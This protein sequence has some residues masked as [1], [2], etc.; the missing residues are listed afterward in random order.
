MEELTKEMYPD[1]IIPSPHGAIGTRTRSQSQGRVTEEGVKKS[2]KSMRGR[3][4]T[5]DQPSE[6]PMPKSSSAPAGT[7]ATTIGIDATGQYSSQETEILAPQTIEDPPVIPSHPEQSQIRPEGNPPSTPD[8]RDPLFTPIPTGPGVNSELRDALWTTPLGP[9]DQQSRIIPS[10]NPILQVTP[11][12]SR[13]DQRQ[14][15]AS[16]W[17]QE[18]QAQLTQKQDIQAT[19]TAESSVS[20]AVSE[21]T[22]LRNSIMGKSHQ[23]QPIAMTYDHLPGYSQNLQDGSV[24]S[25]ASSHGSFTAMRRGLHIFKRDPIWEMLPISYQLK[26]LFNNFLA[27]IRSYSALR[28]I[29]NNEVYSQYKKAQ[30]RIQ[31]ASNDLPQIIDDIITTV[32]ESDIKE[33]F[34]L[35]INNDLD[36]IMSKAGEIRDSLEEETEE[37]EAKLR[38]Q[39]LSV[40]NLI[41]RDFHASTW[42]LNELEP[43]HKENEGADAND[44]IMRDQG[45]A[46]MSKQEH[47]PG[48]EG[49]NLR[50]LHTAGKDQAI[51]HGRSIRFYDDIQEYQYP[52]QP[53]TATPT[54]STLKVKMPPRLLQ[55][56][57]YKNKNQGHP[58]YCCCPS[59]M[60]QIIPPKYHTAYLA[61]RTS[62]NDNPAGQSSKMPGRDDMDTGIIP[63]DQAYRVQEVITPPE[64]NPSISTREHTDTRLSHVTTCAEGRLPPSK[65]GTLLESHKQWQAHSGNQRS[66]APY[67]DGMKVTT[68]DSPC[69][70]AQH[71]EEAQPPRAISDPIREIGS[72]FPRRDV[73]QV[74]KGQEHYDLAPSQP[75]GDNREGVQIGPPH[76]QHQPHHGTHKGMGPSKQ[77]YES[78]WSKGGERSHNPFRRPCQDTHGKSSYPPNEYAH[79]NFNARSSYSHHTPSHPNN[80]FPLRGQRDKN[81]GSRN[82]DHDGNEPRVQQDRPPPDSGSADHHHSGQ[83]LMDHLK[84]KARELERSNR[85]MRA[86]LEEI[87]DPLTKNSHQLTDHLRRRDSTIKFAN[88]HS[89]KAFNFEEQFHKVKQYLSQ[90]A[91]TYYEE[92][93]G[94]AHGLDRQV[95]EAT[96]ETAKKARQ[97]GLTISRPGAGTGNQLHYPNF[98]ESS[99]EMH[100]YEWLAK[101]KEN[102]EIMNTDHNMRAS[103]LK[104][105]LQGNAK[106]VVNE[107]MKTEEEV[108]QTLTDKYGDM[109]VIFK[110][111]NLLHDEV[112]A[113][114]GYNDRN[115]TIMREIVSKVSRHMNLIKRKELMLKYDNI[116]KSYERTLHSVEHFKKLKSLL[117]LAEGAEIHGIEK[118]DPLNAYKRIRG[119][120]EKL[121][122]NSG[123][124]YE[125]LQASTELAARKSPQEVPRVKGKKADYPEIVLYTSA[126]NTGCKICQLQKVEGIGKNHHENHLF[127][128]ANNSHPSSCPNYL[129]MGMSRRKE[130]LQKH[131]ICHYCLK[132]TEIGHKTPFD[133]CRE[134]MLRRKTTIGYKCEIHAC[135]HRTENC[136]VHRAKNLARL[137]KRAKSLKEES[138]IDFIFIGVDEEKPEESDTSSGDYFKSTSPTSPTSS[139]T[140]TLQS[141]AET[142]TVAQIPSPAIHPP[143]QHQNLSLH[144][145]FKLK[146]Y[147]PLKIYMYKETKSDREVYALGEILEVIKQTVKQ[148]N[149]LDSQNESIIF[150]SQALIAVLG[151]SALH[152]SQVRG[153]ILPQLEKLPD[154]DEMAEP[155][156]GSPQY[157]RKI[158]SRDQLFFL[159]PDLLKIIHTMASH[160]EEIKHQLKFTFQKVRELIVKFILSNKESFFDTRNIKVAIVKNSPLGKA[161]GVQAFHHSQL[162]DL[163]MKNLVPASPLLPVITAINQVTK[164]SAIKRHSLEPEQALNQ[165]PPKVNKQT[166]PD[167][168]ERTQQLPELPL[169]MTITKAQQPIEGLETSPLFCPNGFQ[170]LPRESR[171]A[172]EI[173]SE[174]K[175]IML[176]MY[177]KGKTRPL[178]TIFDTG[179]T[180]AVMR[181]DVPGKELIG[182]KLVNSEASLHGFGVASEPMKKYAI[183]IPKMNGG[184]LMVEGHAVDN[185]A[186]V[187]SQET[188]EAVHHL[189]KLAPEN[190]EVQQAKVH[191]HVGG[192]IDLVIGIRYLKHFPQLIFKSNQEYGLYE[193]RLLP[194]Y[195]QYKHCLGG[196]NP[197]WHASPNQESHSTRFCIPPPPLGT[198]VPKNTNCWVT[199]AVHCNVIN[200]APGGRITPE[201]P[202]NDTH[203][204]Q[205]KL[206]VAPPREPLT[207]NATHQDHPIF[208]GTYEARTSNVQEKSN[209]VSHVLRLGSNLPSKGFF[210]ALLK[211]KSRPLLTFFSPHHIGVIIRSDI[212]GNEVELLADDGKTV[213]IL[214]PQA[215]GSKTSTRAHKALQTLDLKVTSPRLG[216]SAFNN[217]KYLR[218]SQPHK[219]YLHIDGPA[220]LIIGKSHKRLHPQP[221]H[222]EETGCLLYQT[223]LQLHTEDYK[224][225]AE[226]I[227]YRANADSTNQPTT[228]S[229]EYCLLTIDSSMGKTYVFEQVVEQAAKPSGIHEATDQDLQALLTRSR[230]KDMLKGTKSHK[231]N[232]N[233]VRLQEDRPLLKGT[234]NDLFSHCTSGPYLP[235]EDE[236]PEKSILWYQ[237]MEG[238]TRPIVTVFD[239]GCSTTVMRDD[240]PGIQL[241]ATKLPDNATTLRGIGGTQGTT[242]RYAILL[243]QADQGYKMAEGYTVKE[244]VKLQDYNIQRAL[245]QI[246]K[247]APT[248]EE[249]QHAQIHPNIGGEIDMLIGIHRL[250]TFP[251][252]VHETNNGLGLYRLKLRSQNINHKYCLGGKYVQSRRRRRNPISLAYIIENIQNSLLTMTGQEALHF[253]QN[254]AKGTAE[255]DLAVLC[256]SADMAENDHI[257]HDRE[258]VIMGIAKPPTNGKLAN[259]PQLKD[260]STRAAFIRELH[261]LLDG[262]LETNY[263]CENCIS[264]LTCKQGESKQM[265]SISQSIEEKL[266]RSTIKFDTETRRFTARLPIQGDASTLL[267]PNRDMAEKS[268]RGQL[269]RISNIPEDINEIKI[270]FDKLV[271]KGFIARLNDL[272]EHIRHEILSQELKHYIPWVLAYK[273]GSLSTPVRIC[274]DA[275]R[276]TPSGKSLNSVLPRGCSDLSLERMAINFAINKIALVA[277]ISKFYNSF[278]LNPQDWNLQLILWQE[279]FDPEGPLTTYVI[280]TLIYGVKSVARHTEL[281]MELLSTQYKTT[282][283]ELHRLLTNCRYVDDL[284]TSVPDQKGADELK[285]RADELLKSVGMVTKGWTM[286]KNKPT[287]D[288]AINGKLAVG[289]YDWDSERDTISIRVPPIHFSKKHKGRITNSKIFEGKTKE[290]LDNFVPENITLRQVT[291]RFASLFDVRGL[292][293]PLMSD[294]KLLLRETG[295]QA[296][297]DWEYILTMELRNKWV[298]ALW[299]IEQLKTLEFPRCTIPSEATSLKGHLFI[300][301]DS[302]G[303]P[304]S[305]LVAYISFPLKNGSW[306]RQFMLAR[307]QLGPEA[308]KI[309]NMELQ[310]LRCG[311]H[312]GNKIKIW[313]GDYVHGKSLA[314][315]SEIALHWVRNENKSLAPFQRNRVREIKSFCGDNE[316]FHIKGKNNPADLGTRVGVRIQDVSPNGNFYQG[317]EFL[318]LGPEGMVANDILKPIQD[319]VLRPEVKEEYYDGLVKRFED[320]T[321]HFAGVVDI[322]RASRLMERHEYSRY[323]LDPL[324]FSWSKVVR[325]MVLAFL[326][327]K[328][329]LLKIESKGL[330][331]SFTRVYNNIFINFE[332]SLV[333]LELLTQSSKLLH[334][335]TKGASKEQVTHKRF[336]SPQQQLHSI[337]KSSADHRQIALAVGWYY[338][339]CASKEA[340]QFCPKGVL[341]RHAR[342]KNGLM[343][344]NNRWEETCVIK[345]TLELKV[346]I[347]EFGIKSDAPFMDRNSPVAVALALHIHTSIANH[348]G[349]EFCRLASMNFIEIYQGQRLFESIAK[350]CIM[351][352]RRVKRKMYAS[353]GQAHPAQLN[354][355]CVMSVCQVDMSG[356]YNVRTHLRAKGTRGRPSVTKVYAVHAVCTM[357]HVSQSMVVEDY[358]SDSFLSAIT[359]LSCNY[360]IPRTILIDPSS[361]EIC[362][363]I[364][365]AV[366]LKDPLG[367]VTMENGINLEICA[368]GGEA[369]A[370][371]GLVER[372]IGMIKNTLEAHWGDISSV[373]ILSFQGILDQVDNVLN[374]TPLGYSQCHERSPTSRLITPNHFRIGRSNNRTPGGPIQLPE[375]RGLMLKTV[376][377]LTQAL[378]K[379]LTIKAIP[380]LLV[381]PKWTKETPVNLNTGDLVLFQK[382]TGALNPKWKMGRV[383]GK[384][385]EHIVELKYSNAE[386]ILLPLSKQD[387]LRPSSVIHHTRRDVRTLV[388]LYSL[389]D[390]STNADLAY[391]QKWHNNRLHEGNLL[392]EVAQ[393]N[394]N[395]NESEV[396]HEPQP[397]TTDRSTPLKVQYTEGEEEIELKTATRG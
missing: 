192:H 347:P 219:T 83:Q 207:R 354:I 6:R 47:C 111:L 316:L 31:G 108:I 385:S 127:N 248:N 302:S 74:E 87:G 162:S 9:K 26:D 393:D 352:K 41:E 225:C 173:P 29:G 186:Y 65:S 115:Q 1:P 157:P 39:G 228:S 50:K 101:M 386:E 264:C 160:D 364:N 220:D 278:D 384:E 356:P 231:T 355:G 342:S 141:M 20:T 117:P 25:L 24:T 301:A 211:G 45:G 144:T 233:L 148:E 359:R 254:P 23:P 214:L 81:P 377:N 84:T 387:T 338:L 284:S 38:H 14:P 224:Y 310:A 48:N 200:S 395:R 189:K 125:Q 276:R 198:A 94:H 263:R 124:L 43:N 331:F 106:V 138:G 357:S 155:A 195:L 11:A 126:T 123:F 299:S 73:N 234:M 327:I 215:D 259:T 72:S 363:L 289:G 140:S 260:I 46:E 78:H 361:T 205:S 114:P 279:D 37:W 350:D 381:K 238:R 396:D 304:K 239:S 197:Y 34:I 176:F 164:Q 193:L 300:F 372:R 8:Q 76:S 268:I 149:L 335:N 96:G 187:N 216:P 274:F 318:T 332:S 258:Q 88:E 66:F 383:A 85:Q 212:L 244:I 392:E 321:D 374:S 146:A 60:I 16:E 307:N 237:L 247:H 322:K 12:S 5:R 4:K 120:F 95:M 89:K 277:D 185:I 172:I 275:S 243:P 133:E 312:M 199:K 306:S 180:S 32:E 154:Q 303:V 280:K 314:T 57:S 270:S 166:S 336:K 21:Y 70:R 122:A 110:S 112:G 230:T 378:V 36:I 69:I 56:Y 370:R 158:P 240:I 143:M 53:D 305:Q 267:A 287:E 221:V 353:F 188:G 320:P 388:K 218:A 286:S 100:L 229:Q 265:M 128:K 119:V 256:Y 134:A 55:E 19:A 330:L 340:K 242:E 44:Q 371:H 64:R 298:T 311:A 319:L 151:M 75:E 203:T 346:D 118:A 129:R 102:F 394:D 121:Q 93:L 293:S 17:D 58:T 273:P 208:V 292:V 325:I 282:Y 156:S 152:I 86:E 163:V 132:P 184:S 252:L 368:V 271:Q 262:D 328:K 349:P 196:N 22:A 40:P 334:S 103:I 79:Y 35:D 380:Q 13:V 397:K 266:L 296:C 360:G 139:P 255:K 175:A 68:T 59:C 351:C 223:C 201:Q 135:P 99:R 362:G 52:A 28:R 97:K 235:A 241:M 82:Q 109:H 226:G 391:L 249:V 269:R 174:G 285:V 288:L 236:Y 324:K 153:Q 63:C 376:T 227:Y 171:D 182:T 170:D 147:S 283:P 341:S 309:P 91:S 98:S 343:V 367:Q 317:P 54:Q 253:P 209:L 2:T 7:R 107:S 71:Q 329:L 161:L 375:T 42:N 194:H 178:A 295:R 297:G 323:L 272:P 137:E 202:D 113:I 290:E 261:R 177:I 61:G 365:A 51:T 150:C 315:D 206:I 10:E 344:S 183:L 281:A 181:K 210:Q 105:H 382:R 167:R 366:T 204:S 291:S 369:H 389:E 49:S 294:V 15:P 222:H 245:D 257:H 313:L 326:F 217:P 131:K 339:K 33:Q 250:D 179:C 165:H 62:D 90:D 136:E 77:N 373:S 104:D 308:S 345:D 80:T 169:D 348:R 116:G 168:T 337:I 145:K 130:W 27:F 191:P 379:Y 358:T 333:P 246:K 251:T 142:E 190:P 18:E 3:G 67:S 232:S 213:T 390:P 30:V 159:K 92:V